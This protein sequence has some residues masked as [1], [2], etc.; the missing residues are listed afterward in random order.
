MFKIYLC[1]IT[2]TIIS[3]STKT[4][5]AQTKPLN[6]VTTAVP[7]LRISTDA[8]AGGMGDVG[9][10]TS[11][12]ANSLFWNRA[13]M[14]FTQNKSAV[15]FSYTPWLRGLGSK[16]IYLLSFAGQHNIDETQ[17]ITA[18]LKYFSLGNVQFSDENGNNLNSSK[19]NELSF[20]VGYS[21]KLS[22]NL[23]LGIALRYIHSKLASG[24]FSGEVY[25]PGSAVAADISLFHDGTSKSEVSGLNWGVSLTNLGSKISYTN[26]ANR[27]DFIPAN[28]GIGAAYVKIFNENTR[29]TVGADINKLLV[30]TPPQLSTAGTGGA[31]TS[32]DSTA[33]ANYRNKSVISSWFSSFGDAPGGGKEELRELQISAGAELVLINM[34]ALRTGYFYES[35]SKGDRKFFTVGAG[36]TFE[37]FNINFSYLIP[38]GNNASSSPLES[39]FRSGLIFDLSK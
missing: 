31:A 29:L 21:R 22:S 5:N 6:V 11:P 15:A 16:D 18:A 39:T 7:F 34:L 28:L 27:K 26:D 4:A 33:I 10:A 9:I 37:R 35:P 17:S 19:P 14:P 2:L 38:S 24:T 30:P 20:D 3:L 1:V 23:G 8:R 25:K 13:K 36:L 12:D 32:S